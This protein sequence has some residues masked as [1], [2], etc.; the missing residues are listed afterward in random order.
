MFPNEKLIQE[1]LPAYQ[2]CIKF[3]E[4][5]QA[6]WEPTS[7]HIPRGYLGATGLLEQVEVIMVFAEPGHPHD[8]ESYNEN[9]TP[10]EMLEE[11]IMHT[12]YKKCSR[13]K[14]IESKSL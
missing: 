7:G 12:Y 6:K 2:P 4:C 3:G 13:R 10:R 11:T 8:K 14:E 5:F 9:A 1:I